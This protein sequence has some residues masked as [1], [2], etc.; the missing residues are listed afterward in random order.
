MIVDALEEEGVNTKTKEKSN[1][2]LSKKLWKGGSSFLHCR[3]DR[4]QR[5]LQINL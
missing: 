1:Q 2:D 5:M 4:D 3:K